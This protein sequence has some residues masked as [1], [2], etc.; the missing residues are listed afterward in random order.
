MGYGESGQDN[1]FWPLFIEMTDRVV[2]ALRLRTWAIR[3]LSAGWTAPPDVELGAWKLFLKAERCAIALSTRAEGDAP[4]LLHAAATVELQRILSAR[5]QLEELGR[6]VAGLGERVVALKGGL[7]ALGNSAG[8]DLMD[9]DVL[10]EPASA[11]R[12]AALLDARGYLVQGRDSPAHL[13]QRRQPY[14]V[15]IE[16]H[17]TLVELSAAEVLKTAEPLAG[18]PGLWKPA[19]ADQVWHALLHTACT[20]PFRRGALRDLILIG[21][22]DAA[23]D[24][25]A[26][27]KLE[28][29]VRADPQREP[30]LRE[31]LRMA[32][33]I[34]D[35]RAPVDLFRQ[36]AAAHYLLS[37]RPARFG[38]AGLRPHVTR[39]VF[40]MLDGEEARRD[41]WYAVWEGRSETSPW[42]VLAGM[43]R[44]WP[45]GGRVA[46][47]LLRIAR[48]PVV[49]GLA[50]AIARRARRLARA[51]D[52]T[53]PRTLDIRSGAP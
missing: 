7:M 23:C 26:Q 50:L 47:R 13:S 20:H 15:H 29:R 32:R 46:R 10:V 3:V 17:H 19:A 16:V 2:D 41:Y 25:G 49:E 12:I 34:R 48:L 33:E 11:P 24:A 21:W 35:D 40:S 39:S 22:A 8:I 43:E 14:A 51:Y 45:L 6:Q 38:E 18:H 9:I 36:E 31:L 42:R 1:M 53:E 37:P 52:R 27:G 5:A 44:A 4:P 30:L 28:E